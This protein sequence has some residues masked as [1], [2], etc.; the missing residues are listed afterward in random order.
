MARKWR[1]TDVRQEAAALEQALD[2]AATNPQ[3][4]TEAKWKAIRALAELVLDAATRQAKAREERQQAHAEQQAWAELETRWTE[5]LQRCTVLQRRHAVAALAARDAA[6]NE[7]AVAQQLTEGADRAAGA[8]SGTAAGARQQA[9]AEGGERQHA[10]VQGWRQSQ[11]QPRKQRKGK[12]RQGE[13]SA[14]SEGRKASNGRL[15]GQLHNAFD[16][17]A[18]ARRRLEEWLPSPG[19]G[20]EERL[21][22]ARALLASK[23]EERERLGRKQPEQRLRRPNVLKK[24]RQAKRLAH[25]GYKCAY[26]SEPGACGCGSGWL[27]C[28]ARRHRRR[29]RDGRGPQQQLPEHA[30]LREAIPASSIGYQLKRAGW[31]EGG[32]LGAQEQGMLEPLAAAAQPRR[33]GLGFDGRAPVPAAQLVERRERRQRLREAKRAAEGAAPAGGQKRQRRL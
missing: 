33:M 16:Q 13:L 24:L 6:T 12:A 18:A 3:D 2:E 5:A 1:R 14:R 17:L 29:G 28:C 23:G 21:A 4:C 11:Q 20:M 9:A 30:S 26:S 15:A 22:Q 10:Q 32:G 7:E 25:L 8:G 31:C 19:A 27:A